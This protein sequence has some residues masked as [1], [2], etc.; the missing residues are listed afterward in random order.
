MQV[1]SLL[2][3]NSMCGQNVTYPA[4]G[5]R[6]H[7]EIG[8][9]SF[10]LSSSYGGRVWRP[11]YSPDQNSGVLNTRTALFSLA[12]MNLLR[13]WM[14]DQF[15]AIFSSTDCGEIATRTIA[16]VTGGWNEA[17]GPTKRTT[18]SRSMRRRYN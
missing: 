3:P 10:V 5:Q 7:P 2:H 1:Y 17:L 6:R 13:P 15:T 12:R 8:H 18:I 14:P 4:S 11:Q 16:N 9:G